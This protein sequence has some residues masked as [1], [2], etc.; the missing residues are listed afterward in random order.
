[1]KFRRFVIGTIAAGFALTIASLFPARAS[2]TQRT[3]TQDW[4]MNGG[5]P[6]NAHYS[7]LAQIN[8]ANVASLEQ[9]WS[10]DTKE[11]GGLQTSPIIVDGVLYGITPAQKVF[12]LDA[13]T[14]RL[15]WKFDA[16]IAGTQPDRGLAFWSSGRDKRIIVGV[17]HFV[18]E[19]DA[20]TGKPIAGFGKE[21]RIDL[22][23]NLSRNDPEPF[24]SLTSPAIVY[25]DLFIVG[26]RNAETLPAP[27]GDIRL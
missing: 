23:E 8:R 21:G 3:A 9:A 13:V 19:L 16:G 6:G 7:P 17:M 22:R 25:K 5:S 11:S 10:F 15:L 20:A 18:Y 24:V 26:G 27:P 4:A 2:Q 12:A 14:G 1:M